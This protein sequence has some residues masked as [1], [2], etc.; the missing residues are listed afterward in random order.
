[1]AVPVVIVVVAAMATFVAAAPAL[2]AAT[3]AISGGRCHIDRVGDRDSPATACLGGIVHELA[4][5]DVRGRRIS[6]AHDT[7]QAGDNRN[8]HDAQGAQAPD[9]QSEPVDHLTASFCR[10]LGRAVLESRIS[11]SFDEDWRSLIRA[12]R[13]MSV[14]KETPPYGCAVTRMGGK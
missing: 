9:Q 14:L 2:V 5:A 7:G 8:C 11:A 6:R 1:V 10:W 13:R 4:G 3:P 12:V